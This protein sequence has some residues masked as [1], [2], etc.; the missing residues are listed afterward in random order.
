MSVLDELLPSEAN[1]DY[2]GSPVAL[3]TFCL[4][5]TVMCGRSL[6]HLLKDDSGVNSIATIHTFFGDPDPNLV[7]YMYSSLWG[8][9]QLIT[10]IIY[11][12]VLVRYRNL[13]PLM[14]SLMLIEIGLRL[15]VGTIHPLSDDF[16]A[17]TPP[18]KLGTVP[19]AIL[20]A[21]MLILSLRHR[22]GEQTDA[23]A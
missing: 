3:Y 1:N 5:A 9:Q 6:I 15:L 23:A 20:S 17:R 22:G 13:V 14:Y 2:R 7:V 12:V 10:V 19:L 16:Y 4:L 21:V 11:A 8:S 18:G